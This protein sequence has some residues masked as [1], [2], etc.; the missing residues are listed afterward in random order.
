MG[1]VCST[2]CKEPRQV[3]ES[4]RTPW[5]QTRTG[6][7]LQSS[8]QLKGFFQ[9]TS[10][11]SVNLVTNYISL[12]ILAARQLRA[13]LTTSSNCMRSFTICLVL[14]CPYGWPLVCFPFVLLSS[15]PIFILLYLYCVG[16][17][18]YPY[19][20]IYIIYTYIIYIYV[21]KDI[22]IKIKMYVY[23]DICI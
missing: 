3:Q 14:Y 5:V 8:Y 18:L 1:C 16:Y 12:F 15:H 20:L 17:I 19:I 4:H 22:R 2:P 13:K 11:D 23:K 9:T 7:L 21:Y 10:V 6:I